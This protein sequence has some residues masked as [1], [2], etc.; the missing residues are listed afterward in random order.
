[1][2]QIEN[3]RTWEVPIV[4]FT[5]EDHGACTLEPVP[6]LNSRPKYL[7]QNPH[8]TRK[9]D[10]SR[11]LA[12]TSPHVMHAPAHHMF[13]YYRHIKRQATYVH[14]TRASWVLQY[15]I[16]YFIHAFSFKFATRWNCYLSLLFCTCRVFFFFFY[17]F[18][19]F[20]DFFFFL[21]VEII[22]IILVED[23]VQSHPNTM[24]AYIWLSLAAFACLLAG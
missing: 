6:T 18:P 9:L 13:R 21:S 8:F 12:Y 15:S 7:I 16:L 14:R 4:Q 22:L 3:D 23:V 2:G 1:M 10:Y 17:I 19:H 20:S 5:V 24:R 11:N